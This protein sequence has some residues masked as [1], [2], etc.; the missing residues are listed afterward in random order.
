MGNKQNNYDSTCI[1]HC[2]GTDIMFTHITM[3]T[4]C[5]EY[6]L[7]SPHLHNVLYSSTFRQ[8]PSLNVHSVLSLKQRPSQMSWSPGWQPFAVQINLL[9]RDTQAKLALIVAQILS[10]CPSICLCVCP[11][12]LECSIAHREPHRLPACMSMNYVTF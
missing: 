2:H 4:T 8:V 6:I 10:I 11:R 3:Q 5:T 1:F 12:Q 9:A 7:Y